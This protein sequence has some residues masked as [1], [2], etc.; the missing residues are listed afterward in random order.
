MSNPDTITATAAEI[1]R[2]FAHY[3]DIA[4]TK[5]VIVTRNGRERNVILSID[6]YHRLLSRSRVAYRAEDTPDEFMDEIDRLIASLPD[7][8]GK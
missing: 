3:A 6:A 1:A 4:L 2:Q 8:E 7:A 5:P